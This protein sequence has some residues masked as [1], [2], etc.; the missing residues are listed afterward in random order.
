MSK[1]P[2]SNTSHIHKSSSIILMIGNFV[3]TFTEQCSL[4]QNFMMP[5]M[6]DASRAQAKHREQVAGYHHPYQGRDGSETTRR[7]RAAIIQCITQP[8]IGGRANPGS[9]SSTGWRGDRGG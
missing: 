2:I 5:L 6:H 1:S 9:R 3:Q 4:H 7:R 8:G